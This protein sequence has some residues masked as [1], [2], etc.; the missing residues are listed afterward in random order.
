MANTETSQKPFII[1]RTFDAPRDLVWEVWTNPEHMKKWFSPKGFKGRVG[2]MELRPGGMY[3]YCLTDP[4]G[5]DMWGKAMYKEIEKPQK[6]VYVNSF[7]DEKGGTTHHPLSPNWP[8]EMLTTI[9]FEEQG[10]QTMVTVVW[11][12]MNATD[13]EKQ[14]FEEGRG[15]M[16]QGWSGT[17]EQLEEY[18]GTVSQ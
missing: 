15:S 14:T 18:L 1:T 2:K 11:V 12:P 9:T 7:S 8:L 16:T 10:D 13:L 5:K 6:I 3:H 17:F 4:E